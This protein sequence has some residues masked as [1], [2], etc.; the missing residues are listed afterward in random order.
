[1]TRGGKAKVS[2]ER[3][4]KSKNMGTEMKLKCLVHLTAV[5]VSLGGTIS[6]HLPPL[7]QRKLITSAS[8]LWPARTTALANVAACFHCRT[9]Q[10]TYGRPG[11]TP[12]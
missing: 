6:L 11:G 1:M 3:G 4:V 9:M 12:V 7:L 10:E 5:I 8:D 2:E